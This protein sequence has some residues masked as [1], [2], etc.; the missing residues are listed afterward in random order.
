MIDT[1]MLRTGMKAVEGFEQSFSRRIFLGRL[2]EPDEI[3]MAV[4]FLLSG[5]AS[6][7]TG[8]E[9]IVDGGNIPSQR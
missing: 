5:E 3:A 9:L 4:R 7:I 8:Q 2:G 1:P 6:Y